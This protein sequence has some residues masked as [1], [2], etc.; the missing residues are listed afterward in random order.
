[1]GAERK[2]NPGKVFIAR[3]PQS[4]DGRD[5]V[6]PRF[7]ADLSELGW[8][9]AERL[10]QRFQELGVKVVLTSDMP[11]TVATA[12]VIRSFAGVPFIVIPGA[13]ER[14]HPQQT[15]GKSRSLPEVKEADVRVRKSWLAGGPR[16]YDE[17]TLE[18]FNDRMEWIW[19]Q[20]EGR[21]ETKVALLSHGNVARGMRTYAE[22]GR[23]TGEQFFSIADNVLLSN[24][25]VCCF[26]RDSMGGRWK[27]E[28]WN[29]E[30]YLAN[31]R[32]GLVV[33]S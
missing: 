12:R 13:H 29:D 23:F 18:E 16:Q 33:S 30:T 32:L 8:K 14:R 6:R 20:I 21:S 15:L 7:E 4:V 27:L 24:I 22:H 5:R 19:A 31:P 9:Q 2:P 1:M 26:V 10:A 17:E 3:H 11:R 25:G 28:Y